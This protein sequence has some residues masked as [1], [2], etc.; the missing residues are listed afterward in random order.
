MRNLLEEFNADHRLRPPTILGVHEH[1]F[2]GSIS[3]LGWFMSNQETNFETIGQRALT[4]P[5]KVHFQYGHLDA[6]DRIFHIINSDKSKASHEINLSQDIFARFNSILRQ[7]NITHHEYILVGKGHDVGLNKISLFE[8]KVTCS[9][10]KQILSKDIYHLGHR[11]NFFHVLSYYFTT[12]GSMMV[13]IV[14]HIFLYGKPY[15]SLSGLESAIT[16]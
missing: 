9:N 14:I 13:V 5:L 7:G 8:A 3:S 4:T 10:G 1:I 16:K 12:V 15:I 2:T 6:F 11:F